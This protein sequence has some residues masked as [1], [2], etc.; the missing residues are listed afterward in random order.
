M[1]S[2]SCKTIRLRVSRLALRSVPVRRAASARFFC[3][4]VRIIEDDL[5]SREDFDFFVIG[6]L[7]VRSAC[8]A[9]TARGRFAFW[10]LRD[11][12]FQPFTHLG[13]VVEVDSTHRREASPRWTV[14]GLLDASESL[15]GHAEH[16]HNVAPP[17]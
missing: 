11:A 14:A 10:G 3:V 4:K 5:L 8:A 16:S 1:S 6:I 7:D 9:P 15:T 2:G 13:Q 17:K 12:R